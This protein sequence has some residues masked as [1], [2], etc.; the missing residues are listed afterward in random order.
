MFTPKTYWT[1]NAPVDLD[2]RLG[3]IVS[4]IAQPIA[5]TIDAAL[6]T[7]LTTCAPCAARRR[8]LNGEKPQTLGNAA[9]SYINAGDGV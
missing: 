5:K 7:H 4:T 3:D 2:L 9:F 8:F 6:G 1:E